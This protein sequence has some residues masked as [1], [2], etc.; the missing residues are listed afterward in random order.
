MKKAITVAQIF[1]GVLFII[2]GIVKGNDPLGL[3]YKMQEFFE[4]WNSG[5]ASSGFFLKGPLI[6]LFQFFHEH[7]LS[8]SIIMIAL[9]IMAGAALLIGWKKNFILNL[10]FVLIVFFTFLTAYAF[11]SGKFKNCGCFGDCLP[12]TPL[13]SF[14]KDVVLLGLIVFLIFGKKYIQPAFTAPVRASFLISFLVISLGLQWY[15]LNYLPPVDCLPYKRGNNIAQQMKIPVGAVPDSFAIRFVYEKEGRQFEFSPE[16]LPSDLGSYKFV[17]R[18]DR[19]VRK[20][21]AEPPIKGFALIGLS[22]MDSTEA[23][24]N[25]SLCFILFC[26]NLKGETK[27]WLP[28]FKELYKTAQKR[29]I[30]VYVATAVSLPAATEFFQKAGLSQIQ[31]FACDNTA[32]R[33]AARTVPTI[34]LLKQGTV[35][36]KYSFKGFNTIQEQ[37]SFK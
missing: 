33:T 5:L 7:S 8:L 24:L 20:G 18:I 34:Y 31:I 25:Q 23:V 27:E 28:E 2:S 21:N 4:I 29:G 3:S 10:L 16:Q 9:E 1:V 32:I 19:L 26:E 15:A 13:T 36:K 12:I 14:L 6:N 11:L 22:G 37:I 17:D 30:P 35:Q